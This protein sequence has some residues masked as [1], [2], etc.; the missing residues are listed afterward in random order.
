MS[1][2]SPGP[3]EGSLWLLWAT[4]IGFAAGVVAVGTGLDRLGGVASR[5]WRALSGAEAA[6][7][8]AL[9]TVSAILTRGI[10]ELRSEVLGFFRFFYAAFL[11]MALAGGRLRLAPGEVP[12]DGQLGWHWLAWLS[13]RPDLMA[14]FENVL[15]ALLV[16][17]AIGLW[18]R[19]AY[20]LIAAG[21]TVWVLVWIESQHSN[22][23]TWLAPLVMILCLVPIPWD[24]ALSVDDALR[25]RRGLPSGAGQ[26][27]QLY[28]YAVWIPGLILGTVWASAAYAKL[29]ISGPAWILGGAVKY[30]WV[31]DA[32][33]AAVAW[34][35]WI[36]THHWV[37]VLMSACGVFFE[38]VFILS[39]FVRP[40][41]LR[42]ALTSAGLALL[43][44]FFLFHGLL[45]WTWWLTFLSFAI[46]WAPLYETVASRVW[47][48]VGATTPPQASSPSRFRGSLRPVHVALIVG[49]CVHAALKLPAGFGRFES[50]SGTFTS[51]REFDQISPLVPLD[52]VWAGYGRTGA[53]LVDDDMAADAIMRL[54]RGET[55]PAWY[56]AEL[57]RV[58]RLDPRV[59]GTHNRLTLT[60]Q[61]TSFD[62]TNGRFNAPGPPLVVGTLTLD[63]MTL[64][65]EEAGVVPSAEAQ[66]R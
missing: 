54:S 58:D 23:H 55:L 65:S 36:A 1:D 45:W 16:L 8:P 42:Y 39:V 43:L 5:L 50:Y 64:V 57:R 3:L 46:P 40:G 24:A 34:G 7:T 10:P 56:V 9:H 21:M 52:Q 12:D 11:F 14:Q 17:F 53:L 26:Q 19:V 51:T 2:V 20:W 4:A 62:W 27:G 6:L 18:T 33:N 30:H 25:R 47:R 35:P 13:S 22:A 44:G 31:L 38:A 59:P 32:P 28:G 63:S 37:A 61:K 60:R 29:D 48:P 49:V 66:S 41:P 15:L